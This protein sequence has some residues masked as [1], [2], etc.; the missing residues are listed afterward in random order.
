MRSRGFWASLGTSKGWREGYEEPASPFLRR[1]SFLDLAA[2][3]GPNSAKYPL[4]GGGS[5]AVEAW[6][7]AA[8]VVFSGALI[9]FLLGGYLAQFLGWDSVAVCQV[10]GAGLGGG[11]AVAF[12]F[13]GR[14]RRRS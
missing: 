14:F 7:V 11:A 9:G 2:S 1:R 5:T 10:V 12:A 4:G 6:V 3:P 8:L 13:G